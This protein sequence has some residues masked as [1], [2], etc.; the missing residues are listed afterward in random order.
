M[1][2]FVESGM[3]FGPFNDADVFR[4]E[5]SKLLEKCAGT[6]TV[7]FIWKKKKTVMVFVEAK[8]SSPIDREGNENKYRDF[9]SEIKN[10][11]I[12]SFNLLEAGLYK[13]RTGYNEI[14][15][16]IRTADYS[17]IQFNFVLI[18]RGHEETWLPPLQRELE[19]ELK[20][21]RR[22]WGSQVFVL[23]DKLA[24]ENSFIA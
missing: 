22:I 20:T 14:P 5:K 1:D 8:S 6:K 16:G 23:N 3:T 12:N 9:I 4:I 7:E 15:E 19:K 17:K 18:I 21:Y 2:A 11:F 13:R 10:K 24:R